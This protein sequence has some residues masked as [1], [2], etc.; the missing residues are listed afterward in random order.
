M[1]DAETSRASVK[2]EF[3]RHFMEQ[4]DV[5]IVSRARTQGQKEPH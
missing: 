3:L 5:F 2:R 4:K 1:I